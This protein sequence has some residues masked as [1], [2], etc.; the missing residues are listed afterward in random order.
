[1]GRVFRYR[2]KVIVR[3]VGQSLFAAQR[4][5]FEQ[6]CCRVCGAIFTAQGRELSLRGGLGSGYIT[7]DG[8]AGAMLIVTALEKYVAARGEVAPAIEG[9][10]TIV[11]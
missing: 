2:D 3:V 7:Y 1:M 4:H 11:R 5:Q 10:I 6:G 9:R 8:S